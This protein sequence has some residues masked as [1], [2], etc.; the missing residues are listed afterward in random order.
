MIYGFTDNPVAQDGM[1]PYIFDTFS[2]EIGFYSKS[3]FAKRDEIVEV[4]QTRRAFIGTCIQNM[5]PFD[6]I[7][8]HVCANVDAIDNPSF[9]DEMRL[10]V[11]SL[12]AQAFCDYDVELDQQ[13]VANARPTIKGGSPRYSWCSSNAL[14]AKP[15]NTYSQF[16]K[17]V[18]LLIIGTVALG[19]LY[20][21]VS[22]ANLI[23]QNTDNSGSSGNWDNSGNTGNSGNSVNQDY[24]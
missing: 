17:A 18:T 10:K 14:D 12:C 4:A 9:N 22:Y 2:P 1:E 8:R 3:S 16:M 7:T 19:I 24:S 20:P 23:S 11:K 15:D 6:F 13:N 5:A 21:I